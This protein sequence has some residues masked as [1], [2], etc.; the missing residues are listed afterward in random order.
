MLADPVIRPMPWFKPSPL[1]D[2]SLSS[3]LGPPVRNW[4]EISFEIKWE[5]WDHT[6]LLLAAALDTHR[7]QE[8]HGCDK[9]DQVATGQSF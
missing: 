9:D 7:T 6:F 5:I 1:V 2:S 4:K 3:S 8:G